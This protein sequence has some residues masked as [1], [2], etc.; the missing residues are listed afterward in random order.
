MSS[1]VFFLKK[2]EAKM[3]PL[4]EKALCGP[5]ER[6]SKY[7]IGSDNW[8]PD[9]EKPESPE[10]SRLEMMMMRCCGIIMIHIEQMFRGQ[11]ASH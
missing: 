11:M 1:I 6:T 2:K 4:G 7:M 10:S 5:M 9:E 3:T 8:Y